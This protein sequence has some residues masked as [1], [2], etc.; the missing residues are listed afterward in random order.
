MVEVYKVYRRE[1]SPK[2]CNKQYEYIKFV[3]VSVGHGAGVIDFMKKV[4]T[5]TDEE[6][7][8][9]VNRCG[10]YG[11]FKLGNLKK[12]YEIEIFPEHAA[13]LKDEMPEGALKDVI[14]DLKE[15]FLVIRK[16]F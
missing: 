14:S 9:V 5:M 7:D 15:G 16:V 4:L 10:E 13:K 11:R 6:Y 1:G 12:F 2:R 3:A 8:D